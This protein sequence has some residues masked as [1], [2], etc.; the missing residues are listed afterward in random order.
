MFKR[1]KR[2]LLLMREYVLG[3]AETQF[4]YLLEY[5]EKKQWKFDVLI[6]HELNKDADI[7]HEDIARMN[8]IRFYELSGG[9]ENGKL[10]RDIMIHIL[11]SSVHTK[12]TACLIYHPNDL[13]FVPFIRIMG[14][15]VVYSERVDASAVADSPYYQRGLKVCRYILANSKYAKEV[16]QRVTGRKVGLIRNG[17]PIVSQF[18]LKETRQIHRI[19]VPA[20]IVQPKNQMLPLYFLKKYSDFNGRIVFAGL[21]EDRAYY[22]KLRQFIRKNGLEDKVEFLGFMKDMSEEYRKADLVLLPSFA[23]GTPNVVLEAYA[24]GRPVIVSDID[25]ERDVVL[26]SALRFGVKNPEEIADCIKYVEELSDDAYRQLIE[27]NRGIVMRD[28]RIEKM[29]NSFYKFLSK[30]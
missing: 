12:Y 9:R 3:G 6:E 22:G 16:L 28:Y 23:E 27:K 30:C 29:A 26:E 4:R 1:E 19:L 20:R 18:P 10:Y 25:V 8:H 11:R 24:Y 14:I 5:A 17:K 2:F 21:V 7:L 15:N 13:V